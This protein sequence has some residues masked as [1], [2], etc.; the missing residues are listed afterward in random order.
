MS[1]K[2]QWL[3]NTN[4]DYTGWLAWWL[5]CSEGFN[6]AWLQPLYC[7]RSSCTLFSGT[8]TEDPGKNMWCC[9]KPLLR[10]GTPSF[11]KTAGLEKSYNSVGYMIYSL[12]RG[13]AK[14]QVKECGY[15]FILQER[16]RM[17]QS[18]ILLWCIF[19]PDYVNK[20]TRLIELL[21]ELSKIIYLKH[22]IQ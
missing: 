8:Q 20:V 6:C 15:I 17:V 5:I 13:I 10:T 16:S 21:W 12:E 1:P 3:T 9:L 4:L 18:L 22:I 2:S 19:L 7:M 14:S 11:P